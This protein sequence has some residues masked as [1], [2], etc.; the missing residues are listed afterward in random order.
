M[1]RL[2]ASLVI[3]AA[4]EAAA[5]EPFWGAELVQPVNVIDGTDDRDSLLALGPSLG[6]SP[7]EI[8]RIRT[9]SGYVGCLS[10]SPSLGSGALISPTTRSSPPRTSSS[11]RAIGAEV[12]L[13]ESSG[14]SEKI[15]LWSI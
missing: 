9:V 12:L 13:Q 3:A 11:L 5:A 1:I 7:E 10:P 6:L 4:S 2:L 14:A 8:D 15:D